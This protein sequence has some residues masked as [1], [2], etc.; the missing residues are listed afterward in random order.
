ML[1]IELLLS[2]RF[3]AVGSHFLLLLRPSLDHLHQIHDVPAALRLSHLL[4]M[5]RVVYM[6]RFY[7]LT[8][9]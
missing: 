3:Q 1:V 4:D 7:Y 5:H 6:L 8:V 2:F 9:K